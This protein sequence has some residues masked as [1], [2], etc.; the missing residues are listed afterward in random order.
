M[1]INRETDYAIRIVRNLNHENV[2]SIE[3][4]AKREQISLTMAHKICRILKK[5]DVVH[6]K[7]GVNGGY[8]LRRPLHELTLFDVY[9]A[10]NDVTEINACLAD[11]ELCP[12]SKNGICKVHLELNRLQAMIHEE[13]KRKPISE[14]I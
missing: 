11:P 7:S 6:S 5:N 2:S 8:M 1:F 14:L 9:G 10:M 4:I 3:D 13:M 12:F